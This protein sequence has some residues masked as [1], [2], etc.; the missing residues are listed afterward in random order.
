MECNN[1][2]IQIVRFDMKHVTFIQILKP[3]WNA[4]EKMQ[5]GEGRGQPEG[6]WLMQCVLSDEGR[7][8]T[9]FIETLHGWREWSEC[10]RKARH[11]KW[12]EKKSFWSPWHAWHLNAWCGCDRSSLYLFHYN[13][14]SHSSRGADWLLQ[15]F[16]LSY[17]IKYTTG[18]LSCVCSKSQQLWLI[19]SAVDQ[20]ETCLD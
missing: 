17:E 18:E 2:F 10:G 20:G 4:V 6:R 1:K 13:P 12:I 7:G 8:D 3:A 14:S 11:K 19:H 15:H 9:P 5:M 16:I